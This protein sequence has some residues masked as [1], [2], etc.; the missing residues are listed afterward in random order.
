[1]RRPWIVGQNIISVAQDARAEADH[2]TLT[3][4]HSIN[5]RE[6]QILEQQERILE[7]LG[8]KGA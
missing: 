3:A 1:M 8:A 5:V 2:E 4:L 7:A 6:L